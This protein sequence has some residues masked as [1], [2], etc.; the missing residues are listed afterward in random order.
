MGNRDAEAERPNSNSVSQALQLLIR[1]VHTLRSYP[2][3]NDRCKRALSQLLPELE[4]VVPFEIDL[5]REGVRL[6]GAEA[7]ETGVERSAI[8]DALYLDGIRRI[9]ATAKQSE[10]LQIAGILDGGDYGIEP[11]DYIL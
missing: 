10:P 9:A 7:S 5:S 6:S 2:A 4:R 11:M 3:E 8:M 1:A